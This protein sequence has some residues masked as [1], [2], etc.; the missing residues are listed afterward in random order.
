MSTTSWFYADQTDDML[1]Y[2]GHGDAPAEIIYAS[3][4]PMFRADGSVNEYADTGEAI[5]VVA[6]KGTGGPTEARWKTFG[7]TVQQWFFDRRF[8]NDGH[9]EITDLAID[10][11]VD[12]WTVEY[13][14][15]ICLELQGDESGFGTHKWGQGDEEL[16]VCCECFT[17]KMIEVLAVAVRS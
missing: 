15:S 12:D 5:I 3:G 6:G 8:K 13:R 14:C 10:L 4:E 16:P 2:D 9:E 11:A 1:R 7:W 17:K